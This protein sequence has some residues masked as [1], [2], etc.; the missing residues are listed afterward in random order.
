MI[1]RS[2]IAAFCLS[3]FLLSSGVFGD[4]LPMGEFRVT[5]PSNYRNLDI[6]LIHGKNNFD[7]SKML[8]LDEAVTAKKIV[9]HETG[10]VNELTV[11]NTS[12]QPVFIQAGDIVKGG[13]QDRTAQD[14]Q[15]VPP[16]SGKVALRSFCVE[17]SRWHKRGNES[18]AVFGSSKKQLA[19]RD[20]KV[21]ARVSKSQ[22]DV[23]YCVDK[24]QKKLSAKTGASVQS[25]QSQSSLQLTLENNNVAR[26][27]KGYNDALSRTV[28]GQ[29]DI[30][31]FAYAVNG[32]M[33]SMDIFGNA[34][35]FQKQWPRM[36]EACSSEALSEIDTTKPFTHP[37]L[38]DAV[39]WAASA[40]K[41]APVTETVNSDNNVSKKENA[42]AVQFESYTKAQP[43]K[44]IH[45]S[46]MTKN[47]VQTSEPPRRPSL[48]LNRASDYVPN[49]TGRRIVPVQ[50]HQ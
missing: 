3:G 33:S 5:G 32:T 18:D 11:E 26:A 15:V 46:V 9:V 44:C 16:K 7:A 23:W 45:K 2:I 17:S 39:A 20:L 40:E 12:D 25:D 19:S 1:K 29:K 24:V 27:T 31:G 34:T 8:T 6:Y 43:G 41:D 30:V 47:Q 49:P 38:T 50:A 14:D 4:T 37:S 21:A 42:K 22:S 28:A 13:R 35:L 36:L 10:E 48:L